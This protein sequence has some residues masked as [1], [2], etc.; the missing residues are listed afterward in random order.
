MTRL[1]ASNIGFSL[2][3][4]SKYKFHQGPELV[5]LRFLGKLDPARSRYVPHFWDIEVPGS[6]VKWN[7][8]NVLKQRLRIEPCPQRFVHPCRRCAVGYENCIGATHQKD[9][10]FEFCADCGEEAHF[11]PE[12]GMG[13]CINCNV[14]RD[15]EKKSYG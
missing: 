10:V 13:R 5:G 11:D 9:Y 7:R 3:K 2:K 12:Y 6:F 4:T 14:K 8:D 15:S 1:V